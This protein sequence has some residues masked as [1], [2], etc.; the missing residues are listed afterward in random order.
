LEIRGGKDRERKEQRSNTSLRIIK[1][2]SMLASRTASLDSLAMT[3]KLCAAGAAGNS[4]ANLHKIS[5]GSD[6]TTR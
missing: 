2:S 3:L 6:L 4:K 1:R 5:K